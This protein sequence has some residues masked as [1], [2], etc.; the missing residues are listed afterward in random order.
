MNITLDPII[1]TER[2]LLRH[3][4]QRDAEQI[5]ERYASD[6]VATKYMALPRHA[7]LAQTVGFVEFCIKQWQLGQGGP[8]LITDRQSGEV[9][10]ST[11]L[12]FETPTRATTGYIL[13][14]SEWGKGLATETLGAIVG[15]GTRN[16]VRRLYA[17]CHTEHRASAHVI[18]K[19]GFV[20]EGRL[21]NHLEFPN[22]IAGVVSDALLYA[23][24]G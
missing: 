6:P 23:W 3:P 12:E 20:F 17:T 14:Q 1:K 7:K 2:L 24:V 4:E 18:E 22:I 8:Y 10:G 9:I 16:G 11:G 5:F 13:R 21:R 19:C 15:L